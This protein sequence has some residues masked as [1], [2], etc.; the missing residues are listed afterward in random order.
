MKGSPARVHQPR[1][2]A[3]QRFRQ[4][5][6]RLPG[7]PQRRRMKLDELEIGDRGAGAIRHGDAV[8]GRHRRIGRL[9]DRPV[10]R[11]P[12]P[13]ATAARAGHARRAVLVQ[14][15]RADARRRALDDAARRRARGL[16]SRRPAAPTRAPQH[17][18]DLAAGGVAGVQHAPRAV[19]AFDRE[20]RR[21]RRRRGRTPRP[22]RS[23]RARSR[24]PPRRAPAPHARRTGRRRRQ[25]CRRHAAPA[26]RPGRP[27][28]RCRPARS[29]CCPRAGSAFVRMR[30][31]PAPAELDGRPQARDAA[32]DDEEVGVKVH[33]SRS[34]P[35][36]LPLRSV[37]ATPAPLEKPAT[38]G[39]L[40]S[41]ASRLQVR[42]LW[43]ISRRNCRRRRSTPA[44]LLD[45]LGV[46]KRRFVVSN[47]TVWR[48]HGDAC[49]GASA[50]EPILIPDGER[51][52]Q[53]ATVGRIYDALI[54]AT[55]DRAS[56]DRRHRRRRGRRHRRVRRGDLPARRAGRPGA[57]DAAGAGRQRDRRQGR[58][59]S[60]AGKNLIG[61]FH[62]PP[63]SSSIPRCWRRCRAASSAPACTRSSSTASSP[64]GRC[65]IASARDLPALFARDR[66]AACPSSPSP[67]AS[68]RRVV[69]EDERER[70]AAGA[71]FRPYDRPRARSGDKV[72]ALPPRR[73]GR[74][75]HARRRRRSPSSAARWRPPSAKRSRRSIAQM[76]PL[77]SVADL[78][79][80]Q[81][82]E[83]VG[84][85]KKVIAG[86]LHFVLPVVLARRRPST[87]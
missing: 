44:A 51:F 53:L 63:P 12:S 36:I 67:A 19:R 65:S 61:A 62:Q 86:R 64:A 48:L 79:A 72:P 22:S 66:R 39:P 11:R 33:A 21:C 37:L 75:R 47:P 45:A 80:Q 10:R 87:M 78:S 5:E 77:P 74:L 2:F 58:R 28:R 73:G 30:T 15:P 56:D 16:T 68:R 4:Q 59:Q 25:S 70:A 46:P 7:D 27:R 17:A 55:A 6:P 40:M 9:A 57:D 76:G 41:D 31:S 3:A 24:G 43:H 42:R 49:R 14:D 69:E 54:R 34:D 26:N 35:A 50:E 82:V 8:A 29:R 20:R 52:K 38:T 60:P 1:A 71:E 13:A 85:D 81:V 23:A 32:A 18:S 83:A 84:R